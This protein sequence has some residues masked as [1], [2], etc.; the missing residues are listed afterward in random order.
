[1]LGGARSGKS[2][3]G[4]LLAEA[5]CSVNLSSVAAELRSGLR[6]KAGRPFEPVLLTA[7]RKP[8]EALI[9]RERW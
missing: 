6:G 1:M 5:L 3:F 9:R 2:A 7:E 4:L 8:L